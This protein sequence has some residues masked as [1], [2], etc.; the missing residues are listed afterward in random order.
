MR[1]FFKDSIKILVLALI[2]LASLFIATGY[3]I[4][5]YTQ[6]VRSEFNSTIT[7]LK[8]KAFLGRKL[9][10]KTYHMEALFQNLIDSKKLANV[11]SYVNEINSL[12]SDIQQILE[13]IEQGGVYREKVAID[14]IDKDFM[15]EKLVYNKPNDN[16]EIKVIELAPKF[17]AIRRSIKDISSKQR[18]LIVNI[19]SLDIRRQY[20]QHVDLYLKLIPQYFNRI[21]KTI[22][23]IYYKSRH[24]IMKLEAQKERKISFLHRLRNIVFTFTFIIGFVLSFYIVKRILFLLKQQELNAGKIERS[25]KELLLSKAEVEQQLNQIKNDE[26]LLLEQNKRLENFAYVTSH[27]LQEPLNTIIGFSDILKNKFRADLGD[28]GYKSIEKIQKASVRMKKL[29]T[30]LLL[31]SRLGENQQIKQGDVNSLLEEIKEDLANVI[32]KN[33]VVF[34]YKKLPKIFVYKNEMKSLML[35]LITNAIKYRKDDVSPV[36]KIKAKQTNDFHHFSVTDNGIGIDMKHREKIFDIFQRL[37]TRD[38]YSGTGIGLAS[39]KRIVE[40]HKG[41]IW[42][43]S[44]EGEGSTFYFTIS[45]HLYNE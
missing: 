26:K 5:L 38:Q 19:D 33:K 15:A 43:E 28:F 4:T 18:E 1:A 14:L 7:N 40:L 39:C 35:N 25:N 21:H 44:K 8:T 17:V 22:N 42:V 6:S 31:Y 34:E 23:T 32:A 45:K 10:E 29:I 37:H 2:I 12:L 3:F 20:S 16:Y 11:D 27:D 13:V 36:I 9:S 24:S 41:E 30:E